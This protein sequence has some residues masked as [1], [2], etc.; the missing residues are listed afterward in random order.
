MKYAIGFFVIVVGVIFVVKTE[1]FVRNFGT[2]AWAE[3]H[4]GTSG[5]TRMMYKLL[6]IAFIFLSL[7]GMTGM[8]GEIFLG[9]FGRLFG[10]QS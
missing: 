1:W 9:V 7:M 10:V 6:G 4:M 2:N 5:G 3:E 8:L